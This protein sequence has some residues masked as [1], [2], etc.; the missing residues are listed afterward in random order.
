MKRLR[1]FAAILTGAA[2]ALAVVT[3]AASAAPLDLPHGMTASYL[4]LDQATGHTFGRGEHKQYRSASVVKLFIALDYLEAHGPGYQIPAGDLNLLRPML[5]SSDDDAASALWKRDGRQEIVNRTVALIGLTDTAPPQ[6]SAWGDTAISAAD[7]VKTYRYILHRANPKY[8]D[9]IMG[10][11]H[12]ATRCASD[13]FDQSFGIPSAV[14][15]SPYA[16]KQGWD[17]FGDA[18]APGQECKSQDPHTQRVLNSP[19]VRAAARLA[20]S[21]DDG[22]D[23]TSRA[24][25]TTGTVGPHDR[26]IVVVLTL[27]P[28]TT[29]WQESAERITRLTRYVYRH[30]ILDD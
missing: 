1:R 27:E 2:A 30:T 29:T 11:L 15:E 6:T 18:P 13:G 7:I 23:L 12:K 22:I 19:E 16:V 25:H 14:G 9:F 8:R 24:M 28:T 20:S 10:N 3:P 4:A 5:R 26:T 17:G 21:G